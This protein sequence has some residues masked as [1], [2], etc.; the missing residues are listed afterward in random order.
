ME[1][2]QTTAAGRQVAAL[3]A[4]LEALSDALLAKEEPQGAV[5]AVVKKVLSQVTSAQD[6]NW[7]VMHDNLYKALLHPESIG[8]HLSSF[9]RHMTGIVLL[10]TGSVLPLAAIYKQKLRPENCCTQQAPAP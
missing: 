2:Y 5:V 10:A 6:V 4:R 8:K 9:Q 7:C 3:H 1:V